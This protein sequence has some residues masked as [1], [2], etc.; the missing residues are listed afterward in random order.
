M[1]K[2]ASFAPLLE[3]EI[4]LNASPSAV[5]NGDNTEQAGRTPHFKKLEVERNI[6][7]L[8]NSLQTSGMKINAAL[9]DSPM[10]FVSTGSE[11]MHPNVIKGSV[12]VARP[13]DSTMVCLTTL[14]F[15]QPKTQPRKA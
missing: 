1:M 11:N 8:K 12:A 10:S 9:Y 6:S 4:P 2:A 7:L 14:S 5:D 13:A 3:E 15:P